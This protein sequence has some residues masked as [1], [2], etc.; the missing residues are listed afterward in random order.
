MSMRVAE[1]NSADAY[2]GP[3]H[4]FPLFSSGAHLRAAWD[5]AGKAANPEAVRA[6]ILAFAK[7]HGLTGKLPKTAQ[8]RVGKAA[9]SEAASAPRESRMRQLL[10]LAYRHE[11]MEG[12]SPQKHA[13]ISWAQEHG[14]AD[15]LPD[16]AHGDMHRLGIDHDHGDG[17]MAHTH[18]VRKAYCPVGKSFLIEKAWSAD[19]GQTCT[20]EGWVS[21]PDPDSEKD[22]VEPEAF[23]A[24]MPG[25][26]ARRMPLSSEHQLKAL[27][28]GHGQRVAIV[29]DGRVL[30]E[31]AHP[32]DAADFE[33]LPDSGSGVYAR[34]VINDSAH[35]NQV[36]KGNVGG[37]SW[38]GNLREY[39][40]LPSG[41]KRFL[42]ID[43]WM[44]STVA[45]YPINGSAVLT[46][47]K[48]YDAQL[49]PLIGEQSVEDTLVKLLEGAL[50]ADERERAA[51]SG[52]PVTPAE[53][54]GI[55]KADLEK[56]FEQLGA[57]IDQKVQA[58]VET[59]VQKAVS[60]SR[61]GVGRRGAGPSTAEEEREA[62]PGAY[63]I[64]KAREAV[65]KGDKVLSQ[66]DKDLIAG[67]T[68]AILSEG[69]R[70]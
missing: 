25:Y 32:T 19:E 5:L 58:A 24:A 51:A 47:A 7:K 67:I 30:H 40:P 29:R 68:V 1:R 6:R 26:V 55:K 62:D 11:D 37:F 64:K 2:A 60:L 17:K 65:E 53:A 4:S 44:E 36:L 33:H 12:D 18:P 39:E 43:P 70:A 50:A 16:E 57:S 22:V 52:Q 14:V 15:D 45:A 28:I 69:M 9:E 38:V 20:I 59:Q 54:T 48:A 66:E 3:H 63:A 31:A 23:L 41:G 10:R 42:R 34:F 56:L 13:L 46:V 21:T 61:E 8:G 35:A 27:P 49:A